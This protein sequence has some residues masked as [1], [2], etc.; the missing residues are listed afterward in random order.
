EE[1]D[2]VDLE[3]FI[4]EDSLRT[5]IETKQDTSFR[6]LDIFKEKLCL[7]D[8]TGEN[9]NGLVKGVDPLFTLDIEQPDF[10]ALDSIKSEMPLEK[11]FSSET[12]IDQTEVETLKDLSN[13]TKPRLQEFTLEESSEDDAPDLIDDYEEL[14]SSELVQYIDDNAAFSF[15]IQFKPPKKLES[16]SLTNGSEKGLQESIIEH[17]GIFHV[18][19]DIPVDTVEVDKDFVSLVDSVLE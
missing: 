16:A 12:Q 8:D 1:L 4:D 9:Q 10:S 11:S 2:E 14:D 15:A 6:N 13:S 5:E 17:N 3:E 7:G 19:K 18:N